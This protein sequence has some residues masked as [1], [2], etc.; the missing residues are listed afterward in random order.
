LVL[1]CTK[2][3]GAAA[4]LADLARI[5]TEAM[6][7]AGEAGTSR[8]SRV[9]CAQL[10][11]LTFVETFGKDPTETTGGDWEKFASW[12]FDFAGAPITH[13]AARDLLRAA[14]GSRRRPS[15]SARRS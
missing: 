11:A 15:H 8:M 1:A 10:L 6:I 4:R 14:K 5:K 7:E 9:A 3:I 2:A 13:N 12:A